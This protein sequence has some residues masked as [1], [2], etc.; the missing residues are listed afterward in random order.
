VFAAVLSLVLLFAVA[1]VGGVGYA[2]SGAQRAAQSVTNVFSPP[3]DDSSRLVA[4]GDRND[5]ADNQYVKECRD[6]VKQKIKAEQ[7]LH[8]ANMAAATT[9]EQKRAELARH[10][11]VMSALRLEKFTCKVRGGGRGR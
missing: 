10:F 6:A 3:A 9:K 1:S 5:P 7:E 8:K 11:A 2:A 4:L